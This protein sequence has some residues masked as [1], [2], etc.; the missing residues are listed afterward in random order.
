MKWN[1]IVHTEKGRINSKRERE[2]QG[3]AANLAVL[4]PVYF[5][6][7]RFLFICTCNK[8]DYGFNK[9][10]KEKETKCV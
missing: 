1:N 3:R 7:T 8:V 4:F 9:N 5:I 2:R 10:Q 6:P